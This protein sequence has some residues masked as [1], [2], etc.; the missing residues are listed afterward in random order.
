MA[1]DSVATAIVTGA[2][3]AIG[4]ACARRLAADGYRVLAADV[5]ADR[6][7]SALAG[8]GGNGGAGE[9]V[10]VVADVAG[11][12]GADAI[13]GAAGGRVDVLLNVA[14]VGDGLM[15]IEE[16]DDERWHRVVAV[17]QTGAF[18][19]TRRVVPI[20]LARGSGVII[21]MASVAGLRG[22]RAGFAYTATKWA[23]VGMA[24]NIAAGLGAQGI[25]A[26]A[27]CPSAIQGA[28][29]LSRGGVSETGRARARRDSGKPAAG[30]PGDVAATVAFLVSDEA[31]HLNGL[32]LPLDAGWLA[33]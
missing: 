16:L 8:T 29:T 15:G 25:R 32:A 24:Q 2:A 13:A 12:G 14:G 31:Q 22:G 19:L 18:L 23:L 30:V 3:G 7:K 17:N 1:E 27:V 6:L 20:M 9:I 5:E 21:N 4:S 33:Y 11:S 28:E 26:H 10:P